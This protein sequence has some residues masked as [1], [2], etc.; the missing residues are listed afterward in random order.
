VAEPILIWGAGAIGGTLGACWA[1]AGLDVL[2]VDVAAEHV[3]ACRTGGLTIEG[4]VEA[5]TQVVPAVTPG[6]VSGRYG[7]VVLAVKAHGTGEALGVLGPHVAADGFVLS[8]QNG[9]NEIA[10]A[11]ALGP[12]RTMGCFVNFGADWLGPGRILYGNRG[13]VVVGEIDGAV[14]ERT[15]AMHELLRLF[16]PEAVLTDGIWG[17]L[18]GKLA[19]GAMLFGTALTKDSMSANFADPARLPA[20][21]ALGREVVAVAR[22][23][24]VR[25]RGFGEFR[26]EAFAPGA[27]EA[28]ARAVIAWLADYTS[29]TAKTHSGVHRDLAVRKRR[30]EV[31]AQVG[32]IAERGR[33][34]GVPTPALD[35]LVE[36]IHAVE[37]GRRP[38]AL[39]TLRELIA[40]CPSASTAAS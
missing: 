18:W 28:Q 33:T 8:A 14:R 9:L 34:R 27:P 12:E 19:Y 36:F 32:I 25:P 6:E 30:T 40:A 4:P 20:W 29:R 21:L 26:P 11:K 10:I 16:E 35:R 5:F 7:R 37:E 23:E 15:R 1:R 24:G 22:A 3:E 38:L 13:A 2:L 17:Y 31:D 39:D